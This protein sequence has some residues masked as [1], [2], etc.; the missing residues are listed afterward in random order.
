[1]DARFRVVRF[2]VIRK[3]TILLADVQCSID[4]II[5][6][7]PANAADF[8]KIVCKWSPDKWTKKGTK[9]QFQKLAVNMTYL[10]TTEEL[11]PVNLDEKT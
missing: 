3:S 7:N 2:C 4:I 6:P 5:D 9:L 8:T 11:A 1:M 10:D